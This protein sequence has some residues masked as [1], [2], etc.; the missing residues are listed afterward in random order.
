MPPA[1]ATHPLLPI[2]TLPA[3]AQGVLEAADGMQA[4]ALDAVPYGLIQLDATGRILAYNATEARLAS[5]P[6]A[7]ALGK[8]FFTEVAPCCKV[9]AF[10]G[11]FADG[12]VRE[13]LDATFRFHFAFKQHPRDVL[14]RLWYARRSRTVWVLVVDEPPPPAAG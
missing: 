1:V 3:D 6:Q 2:S 12:V 13:S 7:A 5:V 10:H 11:R 8:A 14:V 9:P 4:A